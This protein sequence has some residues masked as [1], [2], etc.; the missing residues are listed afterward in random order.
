MKQQI[1]DPFYA[2]SD[3]NRRQIL[4]LLSEDYFSI[5]S[6]AENFDISRP[7]VSKHIKIL[8]AAGFI[9]I[10]NAGRQRLCVLNQDGFNQLQEWINHFDEFWE[11]KLQNL[12]N[13]LNKKSNN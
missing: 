4:K 2:I 9:S 1:S 7:A 3:P 13:L 11:N 5:N 12:E 6:L 10:E 8:D